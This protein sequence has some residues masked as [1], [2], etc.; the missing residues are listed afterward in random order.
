MAAAR[1]KAAPKPPI[2]RQRSVPVKAKVK[3]KAPTQADLLKAARQ[4][5]RDANEA[6]KR[7]NRRVRAVLDPKK[8]P[9]KKGKGKTPVPAGV[10]QATAI[11]GGDAEAGDT[12][13]EALRDDMVLDTSNPILDTLAR[14]NE[15]YSTGKPITAEDKLLAAHFTSG[16][17]NKL[18]FQSSMLK[19]HDQE[20]ELQH[21]S[22][23]WGCE[24]F[25]HEALQRGK[26]NVAQV[27]QYYDYV[28]TEAT[29]INKR[30]HPPVVG[31][32]EDTAQLL[33]KV[34]S[35]LKDNARKD[36][37]RF[38]GTTPQGLELSRK[39]Q[40]QAQKLAKQEAAKTG[41]SPMTI[42][43]PRQRKSK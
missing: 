9:A 20:R 19:A 39:L 31:S 7:V 33:E 42:G 43:H 28:K 38:E 14:V 29:L 23:R 22:A 37:T 2:R 5:A 8:A 24:K 6:E 3:A 15:S 27:L 10:A 36:S 4:K 30:L 40:Y 11:L 21:V 12:V 17:E 32:E 1:K 35:S 41:V 34:D 25:L 13:Q 16:Q 26:L 18:A